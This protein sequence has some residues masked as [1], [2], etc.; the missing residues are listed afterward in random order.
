MKTGR[1]IKGQIP[2]NKGK[3]HSAVLGE[4]NPSKRP[5]VKIRLI[6]IR[7]KRALTER[8]DIICEN[9]GKIKSKR[10]CEMMKHNFCSRECAFEWRKTEEFSNEQ[11]NRVPKKIGKNNNRWKGGITPLTICIR[12]LSEMKQWRKKIFQRDD[13]TCQ[14]CGKKGGILNAHHRKRFNII[15]KE[16]LKEYNQFSPIEDKETLVRLAINYKPFW[17]LNNGQTLCEDCHK[18][19]KEVI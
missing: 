15:L 6:E 4:K 2:W 11:R 19:V 18:M 7:R 13:Y 1:F 12:T 14:D 16:F 3:E 17:E 9:C 10:L 5:D 8:R